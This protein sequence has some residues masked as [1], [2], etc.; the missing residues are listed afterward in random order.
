[1]DTWTAKE[2]NTMWLRD[3]LP[4]TTYFKKSRIMTFGYDSD[5]RAKG[6]V[7][8]MEDWAQTLLTSVNS[9]RM[10]EKVCSRPTTF[11]VCS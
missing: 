8:N 2:N 11:L 1:M 7:M 6:T 4:T 10:S 3:V 9:V 5:M